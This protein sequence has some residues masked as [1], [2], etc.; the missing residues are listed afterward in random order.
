MDKRFLARI[1]RAAGVDDLAGALAR[2]APTDLQ[3]LLLEVYRRRVRHLTPN[4]V[5]GQYERNRFVTPAT[6][7]PR[8]L[9]EFDRRA[10]A[11]LP[12]LYEPMELAPVAPLGVS[13]VLGR[14]SQD[15][16][17]ATARNTEVLSDSTNVLALE[18][19]LRRRRDRS[20]AVKLA[21]THR[22]LRGQDY[23]RAAGQHFRLLALV[24]AGRGPEF[25][26]AS[27]VEQVT[28]YTR[29]L[30][31][32][33]IALTP[34]A[35]DLAHRVRDQLDTQVEVDTSRTS[36]RDYYTQLCFKIYAGDVE[37]C[38]GGFTNWTQLLLGDH[39]ERLLISGLGT[40]R[41]LRFVS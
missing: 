16:A 22:L 13:A 41:A 32:V 33:R 5:L 36:G 37:L 3:S 11:L 40:E 29:L 31:N 25:E 38:D 6:D 7:S 1:D 39:K 14:L 9:L 19:A 18:A 27:V 8:E 2:L 15:W 30:G 23:G 10:V 34:L 17:V 26:L 12:D 24:A 21:A 20:R 28:F 35:S 4:A